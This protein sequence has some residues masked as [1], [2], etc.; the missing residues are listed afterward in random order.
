M[1]P[2]HLLWIFAVPVLLIVAIAALVVTI[3]V[4]TLYFLIKWWQ[5]EMDIGVG[6]PEMG[7]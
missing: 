4:G 7:A 3:P 1:K 5:S 2:C 6:W